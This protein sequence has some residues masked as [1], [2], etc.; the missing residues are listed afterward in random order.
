MAE[1]VAGEMY[2]KLTGQLFEIA[3]Q[4]RQPNKGY[5]FSPVFL[6]DHLQAAIEGKF[7]RP[8]RVW[9]VIRIGT[10]KDIESLAADLKKALCTFYPKSDIEEMLDQTPLHPVEEIVEIILT[11]VLELGLHDYASLE[12]II[13]R[14]ILLGLEPCPAE[15]G[16]QIAL[17]CPNRIYEGWGNHVT[18]IMDPLKAGDG[19]PELYC[20]S[21]D[22]REGLLLRRGFNIAQGDSHADDLIVLAHR[23]FVPRNLSKMSIGQ[24]KPWRTVNIG[25]HK[26]VVGLLE[27]VKKSDRMIGYGFPVWMDEYV[28]RVKLCDREKTIKLILV[29]TADLGFGNN[30]TIREFYERAA[31]YGL[32]LCPGETG[33]QLARQY[34]FQP[35]G[36]DVVIATEPELIIEL[37]AGY[38]LPGIVHDKDGLWFYLRC[39]SLDTRIDPEHRTKFAFMIED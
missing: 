23:I 24:W 6:K 35:F 38:R 25:T 20:I 1:K 7:A 21:R 32:K 34:P 10:Y 31:L 16:P 11:T 14:A 39:G 17:Q 26:S 19:K 15:M 33:L 8:W 27:A 12:E 4:L 2:E 30:P 28:K 18:V 9:G 3:R 37:G 22:S 13:Q 29:N 5:P 36:E